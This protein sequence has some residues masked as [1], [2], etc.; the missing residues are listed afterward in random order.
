[1]IPPKTKKH[2]LVETIHGVKI[3]DPYRWLED[4]ENEDVKKWIEEQNKY[5]E[6]FL[7][8]KTLD[9][10]SSE[11][12]K[13][14]KVTD[15]SSPVFVN[16]RYFYTERKPDEDHSVLYVKN[17]L[18]GPPIEL[19]NPN[20]K[21]K[22]N[23]V[24]ISNWFV[25]NDGK[26]AGYYTSEDGKEMSTLHIKDVDTNKDLE[27]KIE[28]CLGVAVL[29]DESGFFYSQYPQPGTVPKNEERL[30]IKVYFHKIGN[31]IEKD[32]LIFGQE[33]H[34]EERFS[35]SVSPDGKL[36]AI[37]AS[38]NWTENEIYLYNIETKE[39]K[40]LV[41]NIPYNFSLKFLEDKVLIA[42]NYNANNGKVLWNTYGDLYK[43]IDRWREF[44]PEKEFKLLNLRTT[45]SKIL[46]TY[47][48]NVCSE[49]HIFDY[50][51]R[52][53]G[54]LP[55]PKNSSIIGVSARKTE[56]E[57]FYSV[58]SFVF[59]KISY[60]YDPVVLKYLEYRK[61]DNP[62][63]PDD[64]EVR[65][66]WFISKDGTKVPMFIFHKKN[67]AFNTS[68]PTILYGYGGFKK[69]LT[70]SFMRGWVP[71]LEKGGIFAIANIR[72]GGEFGDEWHKSA[73]KEKKQNSFDDFIAAAEY[74]ISKKYT[75]KKHLGI[76]GGSNGGLLVS[77]V[78][79]Q[80]PDLFKA[81]CARVPLTDMVRFPKFGMAV[82]WVHEYGNP[83]V[84]EDL[85][86][87]L[88]WSPYHNVKNQVKYPSF[89][90]TTAENDARVDPLH[91]R[92]MVAILQNINDDN[93][94]LL[95]TETD[96]GHGPGKPIQKIVESQ[97]IALTFFAQKLG[98]NL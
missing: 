35:I 79:L 37:D 75:D 70:P 90:I 32:E 5:T 91:S 34:K 69:S 65:Q 46:V 64:Y 3:S 8:N 59:P 72:G 54:K 87:I 55:M 97:A 77:A 13:N 52:E 15:F 61:T 27:D 68:N 49:V 36:L 57:F 60:R 45:K 24:V 19:F 31:S 51:G 98:L 30:H 11:L 66:E 22:G 21:N 1:M 20:G 2:N 39:I 63:N 29:S 25:S 48:V 80:R 74:L 82:R 47:L 40:S 14:F 92:K 16:G 33:R 50:E 94:A 83:E 38:K 67:I 73:I 23:T 88:K 18:E 7:K 44:I 56:E 43:P 42:T 89:L 85:E 71:W 96:A 62:I 10:F 84:K 53:A 28:R 26:Y 95:F 76:L 6:A 12:V 78:G 93:E 4:A 41:T 86:N 81:I 9:T 58:D 17:S